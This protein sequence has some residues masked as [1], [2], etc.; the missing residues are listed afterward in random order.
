MS[1][2]LALFVI[3]FALISGAVHWRGL[4]HANI[5]PPRIEYRMGVELKSTAVGPK[6]VKLAKNQAAEEAGL[7]VGDVILA[8]DG[9]YAK[10]MKPAELKDFA[11][12]SHNWRKDIILVRN[13]KDVM[14][15]TVDGY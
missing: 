4:A 7:K 15:I 12:G 9:R 5:A 10:T 3:A 1:R 14:T 2:A 8:I 11:I 13:N 6:I